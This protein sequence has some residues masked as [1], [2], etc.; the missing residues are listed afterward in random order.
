MRR[1]CSNP[2]CG[3]QCAEQEAIC[4]VCGS[5]V[6][7]M[8]TSPRAAP[9]SSGG[10][11]AGDALSQLSE[12]CREVMRDGIVSDAEA[13]ELTLWRDRVG[14][15]AWERAL[16]RHGISVRGL[17]ARLAAPVLH[18]RRPSQAIRAGE[19]WSVHFRLTPHERSPRVQLDVWVDAGGKKLER[20]RVPAVPALH[21]PGGI[22]IGFQG[23]A[24]G[25]HVVRVQVEEFLAGRSA[26]WAGWFDLVVDSPSG[27]PTKIVV[28]GNNNTVAG[29]SSIAGMGNLNSA[30][31][32]SA[33]S[34]TSSGDWRPCELTIAVPPPKVKVVEM[35]KVD[36]HPATSL[37]VRR[38]S[39]PPTTG[40]LLLGSEIVI[41]RS[42][43]SNI[44]LRLIALPEPVDQELHAALRTVSNQSLL[45]D[46]ASLTSGLAVRVDNRAGASIAG[47]HFS[48]GSTQFVH[49]APD[50][51]T[52]IDLGTNGRVR[53]DLRG[54]QRRTLLRDVD[55]SEL[56]PESS[57]ALAARKAKLGG[58]RIGVTV[59]GRRRDYVWLLG[60]LAGEDVGFPDPCVQT[61]TA[62]A[63][64][65][66]WL[67]EC[68]PRGGGVQGGT[69][70][71]AWPLVPGAVVEL[72][73]G[74]SFRLT[75][76]IDL[77]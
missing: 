7:E 23:L 30:Y 47:A 46:A 54:L 51:S 4:L 50:Q 2:Q 31:P 44:D 13:E 19:R 48:Q 32:S 6:A 71:R 53:V 56:G 59:D 21:A 36:V 34:S 3:S 37:M 66:A 60:T 62:L 17:Q 69:S 10:D 24:A 57:V 75:S 26:L 61:A 52:I 73:S 43:N 27:G 67:I 22:A 28:K 64:S 45:L 18:F 41:G 42:L 16:E 38:S 5:A 74:R 77:E 11:E 29:G 39:P 76:G 40:R 14:L 70:L 15:S 8:A 25:Q 58:I 33:A 20:Q 72:G 35:P 63:G 49:L 55:R 68:P 9:A 12:Y 1:W 65:C